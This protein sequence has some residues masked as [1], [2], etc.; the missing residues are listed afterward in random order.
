MDRKIYIIIICIKYK[1]ILFVARPKKKNMKDMYNTNRNN[2]FK[3]DEKFV[4]DTVS[5]L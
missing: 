3:A 5:R 1:Y 4:W 2:I